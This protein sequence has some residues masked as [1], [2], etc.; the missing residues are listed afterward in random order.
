MRAHYYQ[1]ITDNQ[2]NLQPNSTVRVLS[3]GTV[4]QVDFPLYPSS[5]SMTPLSNPFISSDGVI[6]F[7]C[8]APMRVDLG[9]VAPGQEEVFY[10]DVD[11]L[12]S[13]ASTVDTSM[14]G[15]GPDSVS[16][17]PSSN[18]P[19]QGSVAV[20]NTAQSTG[21]EST[22]LGHNAVAQGADS[23]ALGSGAQVA[24]TGATGLGQGA[25]ASATNATA[26]GESVAAQGANSTAAGGN[27]TATEDHAT[28]L[29]YSASAQH[30]HA[31][32][33]GAD[34]ATSEPNQVV[35]GT[36]TDT[37]L[38]PNA[39]VIPGPGGVLFAVAVD[40]G[41][42]VQTNYHV[43]PTVPNLLTGDDTEFEGGIGSWTAKANLAATTPLVSST[44]YAHA[45][46]HALKV[47]G[48]T[49][50]GSA[51]LAES[52]HLDAVV[53]GT[54]V[55]SARM[56]RNGALTA[57]VR[58]AFYDS[59]AALIGT[60]TAGRTRSLV[61]A[62]GST[63]KWVWVD[64]RAVAP[65]NTQKVALQVGTPSLDSSGEVFYVDTAS[66]FQVATPV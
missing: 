56:L 6:N 63:A 12:T 52:A 49:T 17:G 53:G 25:V 4:A 35:L 64:V 55:G 45:G 33:V 57:Q 20:G 48:G 27:A 29:G 16:V 46:T 5:D 50:T 32:A 58:L 24:G 36:A 51:A 2:G 39:M 8:E 7:Y 19:G 40:D 42:A 41:G 62:D 59:S 21:M 18:S 66:V 34:A 15:Q 23:T 44:D 54:Y 13:T 14:Q 11:V 37:V 28:A 60:A 26:V 9:V 43:S 47:T 38:V 65:A 31:T 61:L 30:A 3:P 10:Y 22:S 1:L